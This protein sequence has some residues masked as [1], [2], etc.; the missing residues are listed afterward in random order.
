MFSDNIQV[1]NMLKETVVS[2]QSDPHLVDLTLDNLNETQGHL[3]IWL[4]IINQQWHQFL[5]NRFFCFN[6]RN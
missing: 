6:I 2:T 1:E 3:G 4:L 5:R